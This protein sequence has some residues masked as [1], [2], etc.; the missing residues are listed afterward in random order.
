[1]KDYVDKGG[2]DWTEGAKLA[3]TKT[4]VGEG[5]GRS[6]GLGLRGLGLAVSKTG[7]AL[8][9]TKAGKY[10]VDG[11]SDAVEKTSRVL[12]AN[13][14]D[15]PKVIKQISKE[16]SES[17]AAA[18]KAASMAGKLKTSAANKAAQTADDAAKKQP[19]APR[20]LSKNLL[21]APRTQSKKLHHRK[22]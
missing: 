7:Q 22:M 4:L 10:I 18:K 1:M 14:G 9:K 21:K 19:K 12:N 8:S 6:I 11:I 2:D 16:A 3:I 15:V 20:M 13:V 17:A 5:I